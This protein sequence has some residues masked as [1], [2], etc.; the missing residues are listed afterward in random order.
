MYKKRTELNTR[1]NLFGNC[2]LDEDQET[3]EE[4]K[5]NYYCNECS[6]QLNEVEY[7]RGFGFCATCVEL[8]LII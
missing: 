4:N 1:L 3:K 2:F 7:K 6:K 8:D 5:M